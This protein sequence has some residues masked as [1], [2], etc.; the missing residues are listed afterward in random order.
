VLS[1]PTSPY[2]IDRC[3]VRFVHS[4]LG[5]K[6]ARD[7]RITRELGRP[8]IAM[9]HKLST[10]V[11]F[12]TLIPCLSVFMYL[13]TDAMVDG[14][15]LRGIVL[16][17]ALPVLAMLLTNVIIKRA[18][19]PW[20]DMARAFDKMVWRVESDRGYLLIAQQKAEN[21]VANL[22]A[23]FNS[24]ADGI[25]TADSHGNILLFNK[26]AVKMFGYSAEQVIG[27]NVRCLIPTEIRDRHDGHM[28]D[29]FERD[30]TKPMSADRVF[31]G[32]RRSGAVFPLNIAL[33]EIETIDEG[34]QYIALLRDVSSQKEMERL[35][36]ETKERAEKS[37]KLKSEFL[38]TMS[39]E[40]RTPMNGVIGMQELLL[41]SDLNDNQRHLVEIARSS[42]KA[43]M[44]I[45]N[46]ILDISKIESGKLELD[47][48]NFD[49]RRLLSEYV[50]SMQV[51][52]QNKQLELVINIDPK[53][54]Q[55]VRGDYGRLRQILSNVVSNA[56]KF[57]QKGEVAIKVG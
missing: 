41:R 18:M 53:L 44:V 20:E 34:K 52:A 31:S 7:R 15:R 14:V 26:A 40:I 48:V 45:I 43:L 39:H 37:S 4:A 27:K 38:A 13:T 50:D 21:S 32:Q 42:S 9:R 57:T 36:I 30:G 12:F 3:I 23:I 10:I 19:R 11:F 49:I 25:V 46:K 22:N 8:G 6:K 16:A 17:I 55:F 33:T 47:Y 5:A 29:F 54:P 35:I 2:L 1:F 24:A 51:Q 28:H 56:M